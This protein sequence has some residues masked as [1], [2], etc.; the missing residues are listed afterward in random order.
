MPRGVVNFHPIKVRALQADPGV[1]GVKQG[2][3][4]LWVQ[5]KKTGNWS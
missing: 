5:P 3:D 4:E 2:C 1:S